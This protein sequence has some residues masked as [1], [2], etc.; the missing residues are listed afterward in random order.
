MPNTL[1]PIE[2]Y[3]LSASAS[4]VTFSNI[5]QNYTDLKVVMST[6]T[7]Q[8]DVYDSVLVNFNGSSS[9][10]SS[11]FL[12]GNGAAAS[13]STATN[14]FIFQGNGAN[15]TASTFSNGELYVPNYT[16]S[17]NKSFSCDGLSETNATT[18]YTNLTVGLWAQ[19]ATI[20][21]LSIKSL[22]GSFVSGST[23]TL[24][25]ISNGVKATGGTLTV[26]GGY[27]YHTFTSTGS[28]LPSQQ[29]K[30]AAFLVVAG[31]G[32]GGGSNAQSSTNN[33]GGGGG[34]AGGY[35]TDTNFAFV[36]GTPITVMVGGGGT[37]G[38]GTTST[39]ATAGSD[40]VLSRIVSIGG[41]FGG[42]GFSTTAG[43]GG[44]GGGGGFRSD[45]KS[46]V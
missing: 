21:S 22:N 28:F 31:G 9:N 2:T 16:S 42:S 24:Y 18:I 20:T 45:R 27:A 46:V 6:R 26:A 10:L 15:S 8:A 41:G 7:T 4:S 32:G 43:A 3:T 13:S 11:R 44:S 1:I 36:A 17:L 14:G 29:I 34:G 40:S 30:D 33:A 35:R 23:F 19:T 12:Q 5:P 37:G 39:V 38:N 25:G